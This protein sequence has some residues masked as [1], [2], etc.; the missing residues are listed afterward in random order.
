MRVEGKE[1]SAGRRGDGLVEGYKGAIYKI[2]ESPA[3]SSDYAVNQ[4]A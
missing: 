2:V 4:S 1:C 3:P